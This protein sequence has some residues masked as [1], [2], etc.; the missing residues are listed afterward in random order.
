MRNGDPVFVQCF[1]NLVET[2]EYLELIVNDITDRKR[3]EQDLISAK[4]EA[5]FANHTKTQFL[6][7]MSHE[8]RTPL[9]AIIRFSEVMSREIMGPISKTYSQYALDIFTSGHHLLNLITD[10]LDISKVDLDGLNIFD[11]DLDIITAVQDCMRLTKNNADRAEVDVSFVHHNGQAWLRAD[12]TRFKQIILNLLSNAIKFTPKDG[13]I[14]IASGIGQMG[15][16]YIQVK[17]TGRGIAHDD[18]A[19]VLDPFG[20]V[21]DIRNRSHEDSGLGL[22]ICNKLMALHGGELEIISELGV[23]T[24]VCLKFPND[25]V[26]EIAA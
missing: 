9:N 13:R 19:K 1:G 15:E 8:L 22:S 5:E 16:M 12:E 11:D 21:E 24:V 17:D 25:R 18:I 7:N 6:A 2:G 20:Q 4:E 3:V 14:E 10:I 26:I 23:G